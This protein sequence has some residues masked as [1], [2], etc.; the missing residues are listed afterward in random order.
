M[1][2]LARSMNMNPVDLRDLY[3]RRARRGRAVVERLFY[4]K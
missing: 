3:R 2:V 4:D 1:R